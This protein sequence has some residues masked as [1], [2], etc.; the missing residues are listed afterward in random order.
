MS[1]AMF[2]YYYANEK[3]SVEPKKIRVLSV[4]ATNQLAEKI[5]QKASLIEWATRLTTLVAPVKKHTQDYMLQYIQA[6]YDRDFNKF[7]LDT[8]KDFEDSLYFSDIRMPTLKTLSQD[9]IYQ[10]RQ[11]I[12]D[13]IG[14]I[15]E[16]RFENKC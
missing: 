15:V 3:L 10:N 14:T 6:R 11:E 4:G 7:E 5:D 1:P 2:A 9:M 8:T 12:D 16:E 13:L